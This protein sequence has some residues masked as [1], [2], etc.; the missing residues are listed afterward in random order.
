MKNNNIRKIWL[1]SADEEF[2][3]LY[4]FALINENGY[5]VVMNGENTTR[6]DVYDFWRG[7]HRLAASEQRWYEYAFVIEGSFSD[8]KITAVIY[9]K[10][11]KIDGERSHHRSWPSYMK[12]IDTEGPRTRVATLV[13]DPEKTEAS[14]EVLVDNEDIKDIKCLCDECTA[15]MEQYGSSTL[16]EFYR[17]VLAEIRWNYYYDQEEGISYREYLNERK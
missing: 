11:Y 13:L 7:N 17:K 6:H 3:Q 5:R 12:Q 14:I 2:N 9:K 4:R 10:N 1:S 16:V 15:Y 8:D